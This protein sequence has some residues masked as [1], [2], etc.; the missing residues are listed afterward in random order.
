[1]ASSSDHNSTKPRLRAR[2]PIHPRSTSHKKSEYVIESQKFFAPFSLILPF[3][4]Q[5]GSCLRELN[6]NLFLVYYKYCQELNLYVIIIKFYFY[7]G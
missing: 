7:F 4:S 6:L 1:M 3:I 5:F 2:R